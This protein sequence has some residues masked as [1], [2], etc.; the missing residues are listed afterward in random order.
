[1]NQDTVKQNLLKLYKCKEEFTLI[2]SGKKSKKVNGLYKIGKNEII[3]HN[4][5]FNQ[6]EA[7]HNLLFYTAMHELA[8][9]IQFTEHGKKG[10]HS[11]TQLF[12]AI[13]DDLVDTAEK[14]NLYKLDIKKD[15]QKLI[16]EVREISQEIAELQRRL[17]I[18]IN[19]L[20]ENCE[21]NGL[22]FEDVVGRKA[23]ISS[24]TMN[25]CKKV[26]SFDYDADIKIGVDI[27]EAVIQER[28]AD[29]RE[30]IFSAGIEGK[31]VAQAKR[32]TT[33][34]TAN[35]DETVTLIKEKYRIERTIKNLK[36]RLE[37]VDEHLRSKGEL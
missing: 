24:K 17:G 30:A 1:M 31:S 36:H 21:K 19:S 33:A 10:V 5:N 13:L 3:I 4:R 20:H 26:A 12:Y 18:V 14:K 29:K 22:R 27:Q 9:H 11:H 16:D 37:E 8:H 23:Q 32:E 34:P 25:Y 2:F 28:N 35:E 7:A 6:D 15:T